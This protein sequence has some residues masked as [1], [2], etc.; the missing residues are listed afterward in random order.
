MAYYVKTKVELKLGQNEGFNELLQQLV[1]FLAKYRWKL[2]Y[3][4]QPLI[5]D[6]T[7]GLHLWEVEDLNDIPLGMNAA[8]NDPSLAPAMARLPELLNKETLMVMVKTPYSP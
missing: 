5:G 7:E 6:L 8:A 3:G 2:V 4:L 1:P